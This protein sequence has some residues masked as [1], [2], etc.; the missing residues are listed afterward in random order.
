MTRPVAF[1]QAS[2]NRAVKAARR[3]G[4]RVIGITAAGVVLVQDGDFPVALPNHLDD[5]PSPLDK[6]GDIQA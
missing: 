5:S 1:T 3:A 2:I 4:L 6:W